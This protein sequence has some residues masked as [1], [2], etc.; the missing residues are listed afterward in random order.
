[1][2]N[3]SLHLKDYYEFLGEDGKDAVLSLYLPYNMKEMNRQ[4]N[5]RPCILVC[6][7]GG[8]HFCSEREAEPIA[9]NFLNEG[10]NVF[11]LNY[12]V[13]PHKFPSQLL[14][15]AATL[16]LIR[17]NEEEW[18]S[19][20]NKVAIMGFSAGG[21]LAAHYSTCFDCDE[22]R[23][24]FPESYSVAASVL[25]YPV[26]SADE[27]I[28]H[29]GSFKNLTGK[30][31]LNE[32]EIEKFSLENRVSSKTPPT[33]IWHTAED[34]CVPVYNSLAYAKAL[35][36]YKI[37]YQL[38]IFPFGCHGLSTADK[39]TCDK[40]DEKNAINHVWIKEVIDWLNIIM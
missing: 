23:E 1:M 4:N 22:I 17:K 3:I 5:K 32:E 34:D 7:G 8:Y 27:K 16:D 10:Y 31:K 37:P 30:E 33:Y 26:I 28:A 20:S 21:H 6:P 36:N 29:L 12:S 9:L 35:S 24:Y 40:L 18:N 14:E 25:S 11:V 19:D 2:K 39:Q 38:H 13:A 15:V